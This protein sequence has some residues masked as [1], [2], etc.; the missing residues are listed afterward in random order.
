MVPRETSGRLRMRRVRVCTKSASIE[1]ML[2]AAWRM[3]AQSAYQGGG[4]GARRGA[5]AR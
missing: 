1:E 3:L 5:E 2:A 4:T